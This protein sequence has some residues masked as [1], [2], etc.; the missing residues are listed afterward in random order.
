MNLDPRHYWITEPP[1]DRPL[2]VGDLIAVGD[3]EL[4][5][6]YAIVI[7]LADPTTC[8]ATQA[9]L[10][11]VHRL[12]SRPA[13]SVDLC[14]RGNPSWATPLPDWI[15]P[16]VIGTE[17]FA[18][19]RNVTGGH[20]ATQLNRRRLAAHAAP[21]WLNLVDRLSR[22]FTGLSIDGPRFALEHAIRHPDAPRA[23]RT[24]S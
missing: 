10:T 17:W 5:A 7:A 18:D 15:T 9:V 4:S 16:S 24:A 13:L 23:N 11:P 6:D 2:F 21:A 19:L 1:P 3:L 22:F 8:D 14:T 20:G 12:S